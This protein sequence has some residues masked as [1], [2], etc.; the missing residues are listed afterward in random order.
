MFVA[1]AAAMTPA[2][3]TLPV[4]HSRLIPGC[5]VSGAPADAPVPCTTL[6]TPGGIPASWVISASRDA[7]S[8]AHSGGLRTTQFPAARAGPMRHVASMRG[9]FHGVMIATTPAGS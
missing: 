1:A 4:K 3:G 9:A 5:R 8:G 7:V 6:K 2:V